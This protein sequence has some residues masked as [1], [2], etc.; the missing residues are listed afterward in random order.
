M[1]RFH[2]LSEAE[3]DAKK[4]ELL[5]QLSDEDLAMIV[6]E[7]DEAEGGR[8]GFD[9]LKK[10]PAQQAKP[11]PTQQ[12]KPAQ[13]KPQ[14]KKVEPV[15][16][17]EIKQTVD[18]LKPKEKTALVKAAKAE[19]K[20]RETAPK[21]V[22]PAQ[23]GTLKKVVRNLA[24]AA[25]AATV[26]G[27]MFGGN[28]APSSADTNQQAQQVQQDYLSR[29]GDKGK[30]KIVSTR[31][32]NDNPNVTVILS[33]RLNAD[34]TTSYT[35]RGIDSKNNLVYELPAGVTNTSDDLNTM[36][37]VFNSNI[38]FDRPT[39]ILAGT[40]QS[41]LKNSL[42]TPKADQSTFASPITASGSGYTV[43]KWI[44]GGEKSSDW[45]PWMGDKNPSTRE[46]NT[47]VEI[48][49]GKL[50]FHVHN[51]KYFNYDDRFKM[52]SG[53]NLIFSGKFSLI[54]SGV[55]Q[56]VQKEKSDDIVDPTTKKK[57]N[58]ITER[59]FTLNLTNKSFLYTITQYSENKPSVKEVQQWEGSLDSIENKEFKSLKGGIAF[60]S[61]K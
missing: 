4:N 60:R 15:R 59:K 44:E 36:K 2:F 19:L 35:V 17:A 31:S 5:S 21:D 18:Q 53:S 40:I 58:R 42:Q 1:N 22:K 29:P 6:G 24:L 26:I 46:G 3:I 9:P 34:S 49:N 16:K 50:S 56:S 45:Q 33:S 12:V 10:Q 51:T 48:N 39:E 27:G 32:W 61:D 43:A 38:E 14:P 25:L 55:I 23:P 13:P 47:F 37:K 30:Y 41:M 8:F 54:D 20:K 11:Q 52:K 7:L 57:W 28:D